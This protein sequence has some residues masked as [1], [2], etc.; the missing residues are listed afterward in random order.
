MVGTEGQIGL[1]IIIKIEPLKQ[2]QTTIQ[3][4]F[5]ESYKY[6]NTGE[7]FKRVQREQLFPRPRTNPE[8]QYIQLTWS[9]ILHEANITTTTDLPP[10]LLLEELRNEIEDS[11]MSWLRGES[12]IE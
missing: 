10:P 12:R 7:G 6:D 4:G 3:E 5:V 8:T 2:G 9:D 11:T 1:V